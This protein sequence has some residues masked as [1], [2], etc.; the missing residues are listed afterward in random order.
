MKSGVLFSLKAPTGNLPKLFHAHSLGLMRGGIW[1]RY[2]GF[3]ADSF[4]INKKT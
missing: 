2:D 1:V 4:I 3:L